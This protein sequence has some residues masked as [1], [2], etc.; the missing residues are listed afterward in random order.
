MEKKHNSEVILFILLNNVYKADIR[1]LVYKITREVEPL[2][3]DPKINRVVI[4]PNMDVW[5]R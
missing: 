1:K 3:S 5:T 2:H 4:W